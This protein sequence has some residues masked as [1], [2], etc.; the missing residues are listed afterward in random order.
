MKAK[1]TLFYV[2]LANLPDKELTHKEI[3]SILYDGCII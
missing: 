1:Q 2:S 3:K